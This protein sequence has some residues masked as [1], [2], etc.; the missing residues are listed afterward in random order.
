MLSITSLAALFFVFPQSESIQVKSVTVRVLH[1]AEIP[2]R[3]RGVMESLLVKR[4]DRVE[5]GQQIAMLSD[6][7][8]RLKVAEAQ[9]QLNVA[10]EAFKTDTSVKAAKAAIAE[11]ESSVK[12]YEL[13]LIHI[14][15]PTRPY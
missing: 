2:A 13:S 6:D 5:V 14:S 9:L 4:G 12:R 8:A 7:E 3:D 15:E 1:E 11:A 10:T